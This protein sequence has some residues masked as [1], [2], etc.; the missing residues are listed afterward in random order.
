M[1]SAVFAIS[2]KG[3]KAASSHIYIY[4]ELRSWDKAFPLMTERDAVPLQIPA[5][6]LIQAANKAASHCLSSSYFTSF[7]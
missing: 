5:L 7:G 2:L 3:N 1:I 6:A 4:M